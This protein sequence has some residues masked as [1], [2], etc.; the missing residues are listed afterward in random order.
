MLGD[1]EEVAAAITAEPE[2][3]HRLPQLPGLSAASPTATRLFPGR[4]P[5]RALHRLRDRVLPALVTKLGEGITGHV[6]LT[7][8][9]LLTPD[10]RQ[11]EFSVTIPGTDDD[12][13]ESMLAVPTIAGDEVVGATVLSKLGF[14][15][16]DEDDR[17]LL[18]VLASHAAVR[19][20][21][22]SPRSEAERREARVSGAPAAAFA[23]DDVRTHRREIFQRAI[24]TVPTIVPC[25]AAAAYTRARG[26]GGVPRRSRASPSVRTRRNRGRRS[27]TSPRRSR[28]TSCS[29]RPEPFVIPQEVAMQVPADLRFMDDPGAVLV[30]PLRWDADGFGAIV[31]VG[32]PDGAAVRRR[33]PVVRARHRGHHLSARSATRA[34]CRSS[35]ASTE[36]VETL[37]AIFWEADAKDLRLTFVGGRADPVLGPDAGSWPSQGKAWGTTCTSATGTLPSWPCDGPATRAGTRPSNTASAHRAGRTCGSAT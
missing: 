17:R 2:D 16:F 26:N 6:A 5:G 27:P 12:L 15:Q 11:I 21:D 32:E 23:G 19:V 4:L 20:P 18:E 33:C 34:A 30:T 25:V 37:D 35:N 13:L 10:A 24:E 3:D 8:T 1:V 9:S 28:S 29:A 22:R 7:K 36:L 14:A 31:A